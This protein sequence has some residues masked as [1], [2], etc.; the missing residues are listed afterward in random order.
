MTKHRVTFLPADITVEV[1]DGTSILDAA[2]THHIELEHNCGGNCACS[3]CHIIVREGME[4]LTERSEE[5]E[6][7]LEDA[8]GL[9]KTSRLGCQAKI[10]GPI[11]VLIP[12]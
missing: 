2:L 1:D 9:T 7:Q 10:S 11:V 6:D 12:A 4:Y 8:D 5:E 3:T